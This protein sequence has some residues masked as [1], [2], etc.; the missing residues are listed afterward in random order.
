MYLQEAGATSDISDTAIRACDIIAIYHC[1]IEAHLVFEPPSQ[2]AASS[3]PT[4]NIGFEALKNALTDSRA[5][6]N[7][8]SSAPLCH[9]GGQPL[10]AVNARSKGP[11]SAD[12]SGKY[13]IKHAIE[14][15]YLTMESTQEKGA[16]PSWRLS[17]TQDYMDPNCVWT[18]AIYRSD[19]YAT[20]GSQ[21][22]LQHDQTGQFLMAT[23]DLKESTRGNILNEV[24]VTPERPLGGHTYE[25]HP[26]PIT[27][28]NTLLRSR[29]AI[30]SIKRTQKRLSGLKPFPAVAC[31]GE[32]PRAHSATPAQLQAAVT[33]MITS[34]PELQQTQ[35]MLQQELQNLHR[36]Y[37]GI[38]KVCTISDEQDV[39]IREGI[40]DNEQQT[41]L[42]GQGAIPET[43]AVIRIILVTLASPIWA[44]SSDA[45]CAGACAGVRILFR[46]LK[47]LVK[48]C[49]TNQ[50]LLAEHAEFL[51]GY[52]GRDFGVVDTFRQLY[53][54][55]NELLG[56]LEAAQIQLLVEELKQKQLECKQGSRFVS[57]LGLLCK[58]DGRPI[59]NN[60]DLIVDKFV[61]GEQQLLLQVDY[62]EQNGDCMP[63]LREQAQGHAQVEQ[64]LQAIE[65]A[66]SQTVAIPIST[67]YGR[68][69]AIFKVADLN[70]LTSEELLYRY[71]IQSLRLYQSLCLGRNRSAT[72]T[73]L[74]MA[75]LLGLSY[76]K[77]FNVIQSNSV[78]YQVRQE[79][80][81]ILVSLYVDREPHEVL[82]PVRRTSVWGEAR[83]P[84]ATPRGSAHNRHKRVDP[85]AGAFEEH[86]PQEGFS[87][88]KAFSLVYYTEQGGNF[89]YGDPS[90]NLFTSSLISLSH[91]CLK[92]GF[93]H[94]AGEAQ[95]Q[96]PGGMSDLIS[97]LIDLLG[98]N[99]EEFGDPSLQEPS[100]STLPVMKVT[101]CPPIDLSVPLPLTTI[102]HLLQWHHIH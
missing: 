22:L 32:T 101:A 68:T 34:D 76:Q 42:G 81:G 9:H 94:V 16:A 5:L 79:Y 24:A 73:L 82:Q 92:F 87:D 45:L 33:E 10:K 61:I 19:Q 44:I 29:A 15:L 1:G 41:V 97:P 69:D 84:L 80:V 48:E 31:P 62:E 72:D 25:F 58:A 20:P 77:V 51:M 23:P 66:S 91:Q 14:H 43:V 70:T 64:H 86:R 21:M 7:L 12:H 95:F 93:Y 13:R 98:R 100:E 65:G 54:N 47:Q 27:N 18:L 38:I 75:S 4:Y 46:A 83:P 63:M 67:F 50:L 37:S 99:K 56:Q 53:E 11:A 57:L 26:V 35:M 40:A 55:N 39:L 89:N 36:V 71:W 2:D 102:L 85:F 8:Q 52:I 17:A 30:N 49:R 60:Q 3:Q 28:L 88:M 59:R 90:K 6:W 74:S 96:Q 78:P